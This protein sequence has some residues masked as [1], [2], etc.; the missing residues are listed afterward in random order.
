MNRE[1]GSEVRYPSETREEWLLQ[2]GNAPLWP[3]GVSLPFHTNKTVVLTLPLPT[4]RKAPPSGSSA[5]HTPWAPRPHRVS[6]SP[7]GSESR[8]RKRRRCHS[9]TPEPLVLCCTMKSNRADS[10]R[11]FQLKWSCDWELYNCKSRACVWM[12]DNGSV[13]H[14]C[15]GLRGF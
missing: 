11:C 8:Y 12:R 10:A 9:T 6:Q 14:V 15:S 7:Y 5:K 2:K 1:L 3:A 4:Q 13:R